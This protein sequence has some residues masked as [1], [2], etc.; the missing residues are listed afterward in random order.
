ML[1]L[2][3]GSEQIQAGQSQL[4]LWEGYGASLSGS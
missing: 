2:Q 4:N 3:G 1:K